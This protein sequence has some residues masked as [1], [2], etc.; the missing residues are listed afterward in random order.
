MGAQRVVHLAMRGYISWESE[1]SR[2]FEIQGLQAALTA[3]ECCKQ[4]ILV[5]WSFKMT[6]REGKASLR[7]PSLFAQVVGHRHP[8]GFGQTGG[9]KRY[10]INRRSVLANKCVGGTYLCSLL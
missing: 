9:S 10:A 2:I 1:G 5:V 6:S 3:S 7:V 4:C 8:I